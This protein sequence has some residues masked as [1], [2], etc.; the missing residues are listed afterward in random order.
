MFLF[1]PCLVVNIYRET[2]LNLLLP[3]GISTDAAADADIG[4]ASLLLLLPLACLC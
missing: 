4:E 2:D 3:S 1:W